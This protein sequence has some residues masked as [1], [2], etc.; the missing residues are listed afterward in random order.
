MGL[1]VIG[2]VV[3]SRKFDHAR[4]D[5][6]HA[7]YSSAGGEFDCIGRCATSHVDR[8]SSLLRRIVVCW[9]TL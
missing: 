9:L 1:W 7:S 2:P 6:G 4:G 5:V 8:A 3:A